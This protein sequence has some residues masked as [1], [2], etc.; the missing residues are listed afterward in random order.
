MPRPPYLFAGNSL[1]QV[2]ESTL[3]RVVE[4]VDETPE[5][6]VLRVDAEA[7]I[8]ALVERLSLHVP[9]LGEPYQDQAEDV[10]IDISRESFA[11]VVSYVGQTIPGYRVTVHVPFT[12]DGALFMLQPS[13]WTT[14]N[15]IGQVGQ[16][17]LLYFFEYPHDRHENIKA[18]ADRFIQ[19]VEKH[20]RWV[21]SDLD[22]YNRKLEAKARAAVQNRRERIKRH[23]EHLAATG[24]P[25][26]APSESATYIAD[27]I[28]RRPAPVLPS[29]PENTPIA[30]E[31]VMEEDVFTHILGVIRSVGQ[32][33]E[34]SPKTFAPMAEED[35]RQVFLAAL[36]PSYRGQTT[37]EAFNFNGKTDLL[38]RHD[39]KNL[40]I[41][42]CKF[43]S[44]AKGFGETINQL[45]RYRAWRDTKLAIV[46][47]VREKNLTTILENAKQ[48]LL[49]H[50]Q[51]AELRDSVSET[52]L[53]ARMT[54]PGDDRRQ[55]DLN[56]FL[57]Q[58]APSA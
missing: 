58:I 34:R 21:E 15:P 10:K 26:K 27:A 14:M 18:H 43:W 5:E 54:W 50:P 31:P 12:G 7:W 36:N 11:R 3:G 44:G 41:A 53:R 29:A 35:L 1:H 39:G 6:H 28:I 52:E 17:E 40:F 57:F 16:G 25:I 42:E 45:F 4:D 46:T 33:M 49:E 20:L 22:E 9:T 51:F 32:D 48:A 38:I 30:L 19:D 23:R 8:A 2:L 56:I 37:A 13:T 55:A 24:L 47:F